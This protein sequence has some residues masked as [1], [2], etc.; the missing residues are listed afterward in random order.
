MS[1]RAHESWVRGVMVHLSGNYV[2]SC[3]DDQT[4]RVFDIKVRH[5]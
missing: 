2:L 4:I 1:F 3:G 5:L